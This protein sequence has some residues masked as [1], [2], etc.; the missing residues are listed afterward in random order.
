MKNRWT[1]THPDTDIPSAIGDATYAIPK[2]DRYIEDASYLR[3]KNISLSYVFP[4]SLISKWRL[5]RAKIYISG[6]NLFTFT[7]YSGFDPEAATD[8]DVRGGVDLATFPEQKIYTLGLD[9]SL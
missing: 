2:S 8:V 1:P 4:E 3:I 9:I 7:N 5:Q 6:Y